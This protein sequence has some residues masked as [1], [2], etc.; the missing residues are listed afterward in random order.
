MGVHY[1]RVRKYKRNGGYSEEGL[2]IYK[3]E[4]G[5][6]VVDL[7][8]KKNITFN[9]YLDSKIF[10]NRKKAFTKFLLIFSFIK[11]QKNIIDLLIV[12]NLD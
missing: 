2:K 11:L 4:G 7:L 5:R 12:E 3:G 8:G 10:W 9:P 1:T 6:G